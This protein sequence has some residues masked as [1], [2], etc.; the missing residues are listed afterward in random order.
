MYIGLDIGSVSVNAVLVDDEKRILEEHYVR[1]H[2]Q[3]IETSRNVLEDMLSRTPL[4]KIKGLALTG[5]GG[6]ILAR[7]MG[8]LFVNE[9]VA[10]TK[11]TSLLHPEVRT[12]IEIG[13]EDSKLILLERD[14][15]DSESRVADFS[16]NTICAAG[17]GSFLDQQASRLGLTIEEFGELA[18]KSKKPPRIAG[19]C[20]VFAKTDMIH[21]Q[22]E[23][24]PDYDIVAGL[25]HAM[26][27]NFKA[28]IGKGKE[29]VKPV[30]F[31]GGVAANKGMVRGF[32]DALDLEPGELIIP[33][34]FASMGAI[35]AVL[36]ALESGQQSPLA[37]LESID[38][39]L[40]TRKVET[41]SHPSLKGEEYPLVMESIPFE[42]EKIDVWVG[43]DVGSISTCVAVI[44]KDV[45][46]ISRRY[47]MTA[48]R[49]LE[50]VTRGLYE[51]G[52]E[53]G[54]RVIVR[55]AC[56][57]GSGRYL[58][59]DFIGADLVKNE[60]TT[61]ATA[62]AFYNPKVDT[63]FEI[64]GQDS[65]YA[66][67]EN[68]AIV[69]FTMNKVCAAGTGSFLE[70][71]AER[72]G[73][74]IIGEF[75]ELALGA[76]KPAY[77]GE[78]CTVFM[79]SDL[80]RHQQQGVPKDDLVAGLSYSIVYNYLTRVVEDRKVGDV[81]F[82]QGGVA[83]NRGVK[84]AFESI[85]GKKVI[86]PPHHDLLGAIG[87]AMVVKENFH[88]LKSK[89][90]GFDLR[91]RKYELTTFE[92]QD[93]PNRCEVH[94]VK[95]EG[96]LPLHYGSRCGKYD[97]V[98]EPSKGEHLPRL[99]QEREQILLNSYNKKP[100]G[101]VLG[102]VGIPQVTSFFELF[103]FFKAF[104]TELGYEVV[105]SQATNK[106]II[107][108]GLE[109]VLAEPCFPIKVAHGHIYNLLEK[110]I[111][112][113]FLPSIVNMSE[114]GEGFTHSFNCPYVQSLPY[115]IRSAI[116]LEKSPIKLLQP[117][118]HFE[119]GRKYARRELYRFA[120]TLTSDTQRIKRALETAEEVQEKFSSD[121]ER[122]GQEI[123][124]RLGEDEIVLVI[125]SR[126]YNGCDPGLNLN[127]PE[128]LRDMGVMAIPLDMLPL[129]QED[130][131]D[132]FP[133]MYWK[134]G[135]R[136]LTAARAIRNDPRLN[137]VYITNFGCGPDSF[138]M[139]FFAKEIAR[140]YLTIEIDEHSADVG[141]ITRLEAFLD[142]LKNVRG[143]KPVPV[144]AGKWQYDLRREPKRTVFVPYMDDHG[145]IL[146]AAMR[147][148]NQPAEQLPLSDEKTLEI[149]RK[150]TT[151]K[152]CYPCIITTGD[153]MKK[154]LSPDFDPGRSAFLMPTAFG[155]CRFGQYNKFHRILLD[156]LGFQQVP[157]V[158][159]DQTK[160]F[161]K[162]LKNFGANF[163]KLAW[164]GIIFVDSIQ[165]LLHQIRPFE[166]NKGETDA[167]YEYYLKKAED[168]VES[169]RGLL[170]LALEARRAF[171][172]IPTDRS[173]P[174]PLVGIVGEIFV[175]S[176][177]FS[178]NFIVR[179]V[180]E[181]GGEVV[182]PPMEE[183]I[184]Y[185]N[186]V[187]KEDFLIDKEMKGF[188]VELITEVVQHSYRERMLAP[189]RGAI[190]HFYHESST[191]H[192]FHLARP[193]LDSTIRGE[194]VLSM[195]RVVEYA[196]ENFDGVINVTPFNC[197]P[198]N[199]VNTLLEPFRRD[200]DNIP[201]LKLA[202]DGLEQTSELTRVEAF[203]HQAKEYAQR[204]MRKP[205]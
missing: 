9:I 163:K 110:D 141:A 107:E 25:C 83:A 98:K 116:D 135:Q 176:N 114:L 90:K 166:V 140:P 78:R 48:G 14:E 31:Q 151:G 186:Q 81:I 148:H 129:S 161:E 202:Y 39:Y 92:C 41:K 137:A 126:P 26:A 123:L 167:L 35:G 3:A 156:E 55:G 19:R 127:I 178:N 99:F 69:D 77:L 58:T 7:I 101:P 52:Q 82:F 46:V 4:E 91:H 100:E 152:E 22:Q 30:A 104:F 205:S 196:L 10:Q 201:V 80:N 47:L 187:R 93:C 94:C 120:R 40:K 139:K 67:L 132:D 79:E 143:R 130:I 179:S 68:G 117:T 96:E 42:G 174:R 199:I 13:G 162:D 121:L 86:V 157:I 125:V 173:Q 33:K 147:Y 87:A 54:D 146:A 20:S 149:G 184:N 164:K 15:A 43:V 50:A 189:F 74:N 66:S 89:F 198:G 118:I 5:S 158:I 63:I 190:R 1:T 153:I 60:I 37:G 72:L 172:A 169:G 84:A 29:F 59:G 106:P 73:I 195:G 204:K 56:T 88:G 11:A 65:K 61:H 168:Y 203:M 136:I 193:Y 49:P 36:A 119:L 53:V 113:I 23:A 70:E 171:E 165:K 197:M 103:P 183:W 124:S 122:R 170:P 154:A 64:G 8:A 133:H 85:L 109:S 112:Y 155:P 188:L 192:I 18:L 62:A 75:G 175:R 51:V 150:Y 191:R 38:E 6:K 12:V 160:E 24:T 115:L 34:H 194:A 2:G 111:D 45:N 177:Q 27:R 142:S 145:Y 134:Y 28:N 144:R 17:T 128:K 97:V 138:I 76:G 71:Q 95:V 102:K 57:T 159:L 105:L 108:K 182:L 180:E 185:I 44:D 16:M 32:E 21:L 131:S 200:Y 181:L